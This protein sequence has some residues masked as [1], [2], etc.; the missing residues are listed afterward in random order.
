MITWD[1]L[2]R[3]LDGA[4]NR[5]ERTRVPID[6]LDCMAKANLYLE[7][8]W[9]SSRSVCL[10]FNSCSLT[11]RQGQQHASFPPWLKEPQ[12]SLAV[13][14]ELV[15]VPSRM[16][17]TISLKESLMAPRVLLKLPGKR[18]LRKM[19]MTTMTTTTRRRRMMNKETV[20]LFPCENT[21]ERCNEHLSYLRRVCCPH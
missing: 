7:V 18:W 4:V 3:G 8:T 2:G 19:R 13:H 1:P 14:L 21:L 15:L 20:Y 16:S 10:L 17:P 6:F 11:L 9:N 12:E 5:P